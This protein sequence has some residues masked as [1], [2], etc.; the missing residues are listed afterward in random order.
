MARELVA[1]GSSPDRTSGSMNAK[2]KAGCP[3]VRWPAFIL[4]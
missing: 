1:E 3:G 2:A 4:A